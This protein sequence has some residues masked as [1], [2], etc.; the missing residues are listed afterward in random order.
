M[1]LRWY[2]N[3]CIQ[4]TTLDGTSILCDPW[5][6]P[7]ANLGSWFHW[8]PIPDDFENHLINSKLDGIFISHLHSDHYDPK[9][10]SK[11]S[12]IRPEIPIYIPEFAHA[13]L[14]RSLESVVQ[15]KSQ[16]IEIPLLKD[17]E[18]GSGLKL[19]AFPADTCNPEICLKSIPCQTEPSLR[20]I[21]GIVVFKGDGKVVVNANDAMSIDL[22]PKVAA[23]IGRADVLMGHYGAASPFPQ[24]FP[25]IADKDSAAMEIIERSAN[26]LVK[27]AD[28]VSAKYIFPFAG[29]YIL[30]G[31]LQNLNN[32][33]AILPLDQTVKLLEKKTDKCILSVKPFGEI[34]LFDLTRHVPYVEPSEEVKTKYLEK[35][36]KVK[37]LYERNDQK[38][39]DD[40]ELDLVNA[41]RAIIEKSRK[42]KI[43]VDNSFVIGDGKNYITINLFIDSQKNFAEYG[44][45]PGSTIVTRITMPQSL[46]RMLSQRKSNFSGFTPLHWNQADGGSHFTWVRVGE[47]DL[48]SHMLLNFFGT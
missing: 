24:C 22:V 42:A 6:N 1:R 26:M 46:L 7:G 19:M 3:A 18:V 2:S 28:A 10:I 11:F 44:N 16:V 4:I 39:W 23:N 35:I 48:N 27:A 12:K 8:P 32:D 14:K 17:Y 37:F 25:E 15:N 20:G 30:G 45:C 29:Q 34:D 9:F 21:D 31:R 5:V 41:A 13:W 33:L 38:V 40:P 47:F 43:R 36:S